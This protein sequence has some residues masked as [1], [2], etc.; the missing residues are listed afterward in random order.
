MRFGP[1]SR[2]SASQL[3]FE[4]RLFAIRQ[5]ANYINDLYYRKYCMN[6]FTFISGPNRC[7]VSELL[8]AQNNSHTDWLIIVLKHFGV[9]VNSSNRRS[10]KKKVIWNNQRLPLHNAVKFCNN[11]NNY[12]SN[13]VEDV[14][15]RRGSVLLLKL[16]GPDMNKLLLIFP[17]FNHRDAGN[18][19]IKHT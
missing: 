18:F 11:N 4:I 12:N 7:P 13:A 10:W 16:L 14:P 1:H 3:D 17:P 6:S 9:K 15:D 8:G 2:G 19:E 5:P